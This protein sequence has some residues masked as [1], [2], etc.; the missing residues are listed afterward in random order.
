[1]RLG[2]TC[3]LVRRLALVD[4]GRGYR[5]PKTDPTTILKCARK[6]NDK[7]VMGPAQPS[8][9]YPKKNVVAF[10]L[11]SSPISMLTVMLLPLGAQS[12]ILV[13]YHT[14]TSLLPCDPFCLSPLRQLILHPAIL[15]SP[16]SST[17][18]FRRGERHTKN[19]DNHIP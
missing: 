11:S 19:F 1:M 8:Y 5:R 16:I 18:N 4:V 17:Q 6:Y 14:C 9:P 7:L 12:S 15:Y 10:L 3:G 13:L 2:H